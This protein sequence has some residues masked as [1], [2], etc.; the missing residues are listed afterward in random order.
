MKSKKKTKKKVQKTPVE[1]Y[2]VNMWLTF[3]PP[4]ANGLREFYEERFPLQR[5]KD[6]WSFEV[7]ASNLAGVASELNR[8]I[9]D[10]CENY[11]KLDCGSRASAVEVFTAK[12]WNDLGGGQHESGD[13]KQI[14][15]LVGSKSPTWKFAG[16]H[17]MYAACRFY[18]K[19]RAKK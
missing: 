4:E 13:K 8:K 19:P 1:K 12:V 3:D 5:S 14:V 10:E 9:F 2:Q 17:Y 15:V 16:E 18:I 11:I 7:S 6:W